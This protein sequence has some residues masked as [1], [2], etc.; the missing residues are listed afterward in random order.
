MSMT[1]HNFRIGSI[2]VSILL[3]VK[4]GELALL[5]MARRLH[6]ITIY[7][8]DSACLGIRAFA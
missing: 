7:E 1:R 8:T 6:L 5:V 4:D 3:P 2:G